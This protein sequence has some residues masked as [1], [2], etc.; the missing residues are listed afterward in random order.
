[1]RFSPP[2]HAL[3]YL[4]LLRSQ[5]AFV[6]LSENASCLRSL[7]FFLAVLKR[8]YGP[9]K[10]TANYSNTISSVAFAGTVV[11]MLVFGYLSDK[12][13]RKFGMVRT[14]SIAPIANGA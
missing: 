6:F 4:A 1:M 2:E 7:P 9:E 13:G 12:L 5:Y 14:A 8:I 3:T 11:G 10:I